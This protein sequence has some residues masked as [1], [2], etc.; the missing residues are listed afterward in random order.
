ML[1]E[2]RQSGSGRKM[3]REKTHICSLKIDTNMTY[4]KCATVGQSET[5]GV[6]NK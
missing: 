1:Q 4:A 3:D 6:S 5:D 2:F